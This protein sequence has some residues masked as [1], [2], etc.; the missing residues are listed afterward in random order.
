MEAIV[1]R[2]GG[3]EFCRGAIVEMSSSRSLSSP[4]LHDGDLEPMKDYVESAQCT[5]R[6]NNY[7]GC[8]PFVS[9]SLMDVCSN[10]VG[11]RP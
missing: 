3:A 11:C 5:K 2:S 8:L 9:T 1:R 4:W 10:L 7:P 6:I